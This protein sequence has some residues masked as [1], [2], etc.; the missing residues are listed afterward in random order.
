MLIFCNASEDSEVLKLYHVESIVL[1]SLTWV[2]ESRHFFKTLSDPVISDLCKNISL[3][4]FCMRA[5]FLSSKIIYYNI[6]FMHIFNGLPVHCNEFNGHYW[7][8]L[9]AAVLLF[10]GRQLVILYWSEIIMHLLIDKRIGL[11][12]WNSFESTQT[13]IAFAFGHTFVLESYIWTHSLHSSVT[14]NHIQVLKWC[15]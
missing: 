7:Q 1:A 11:A 14:S 3:Y 9:V 12:K 13:I 10:N 6:L 8:I 2:L 15:I 4:L 5:C